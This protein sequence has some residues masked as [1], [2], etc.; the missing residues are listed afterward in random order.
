M[1]D[2]STIAKHILVVE[3]EPDFAALLRSILARAAVDFASIL[4]K[5][6]A[7]SFSLNI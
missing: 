7:R 4:K 3:D 5:I 6:C 2:D 1:T